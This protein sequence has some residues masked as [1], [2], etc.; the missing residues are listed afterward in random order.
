MVRPSQTL[1]AGGVRD[2]HAVELLATSQNLCF[3]I[4]KSRL[5]PTPPC[6][7]TRQPS[8]PSPRYRGRPTSRGL[9]RRSS[10][11]RGPQRR[12]SPA[13][14]SQLARRGLPPSIAGTAMRHR[15]LHVDWKQYVTERVILTVYVLLEIIIMGSWVKLESLR[16]ALNDDSV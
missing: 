6:P 1:V 16:E 2:G 15:L 10:L 3:T 8:R 13:S 7:S 5:L 9:R 12:T 11:W 14:G 4:E